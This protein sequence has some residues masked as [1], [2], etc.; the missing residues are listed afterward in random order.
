MAVPST[1]EDPRTSETTHHLYRTFKCCYIALRKS[2]RPIPQTVGS[3]GAQWGDVY[4]LAQTATFDPRSLVPLGVARPLCKTSLTGNDRLTRYKLVP[5]HGVCI[6]WHECL[7]ALAA[8]GCNKR[9]TSDG[10]RNP[11]LL[12]RSVTFPIFLPSSF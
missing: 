2:T 7:D 12:S 4:S 9:M 6:H 8:A 10:G 5:L 3:F 1:H 11:L